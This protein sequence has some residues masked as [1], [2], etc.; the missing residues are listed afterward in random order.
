MISTHQSIV[1]NNKQS[2]VACHWYFRPAFTI[3]GFNIFLHFLCIWPSILF[4]YQNYIN[5][6][7]RFV[8]NI[9][10]VVNYT[11][12]NIHLTPISS[13]VSTPECYKIISD[14]SAY[15][16]SIGQPVTYLPRVLYFYISIFQIKCPTL[17]D[18]TNHG[19]GLPRAGLHI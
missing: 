17:L 6:I 15:R 10:G 12:H 5:L 3:L 4:L 19:W 7:F 11:S 13:P 14:T 9:T 2:R 1:L 8:I 16:I 18:Q